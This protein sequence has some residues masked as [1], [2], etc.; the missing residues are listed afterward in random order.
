VSA[1]PATLDQ[2]PPEALLADYPPPMAAL[3]ERLRAIVRGAVPDAVERVRVGWRI[4]GYDLPVGRRRTVFF[5]W[6]MPERVHVHLG[7]PKGILLDDPEGL[8]SGTG[9]TKQARW[10]TADEPADIDAD[11]FTAYTRQAAALSGLSPSERY[12]RLLDREVAGRTGR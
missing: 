10:L 6:I 8:L 1:A 2:I 9:I 7:F 5:A 3:G 4:V 11:V 12:A